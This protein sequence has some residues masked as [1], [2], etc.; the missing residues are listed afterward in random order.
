[1]YDLKQMTDRIKVLKMKHNLNS[2]ELAELAGVPIGTLNKVL[3]TETKDPQLSTVMKIAS[4][5][6]VDTD[7]L[8]YGRSSGRNSM[9]SEHEENVVIAYR[10]NIDMQ[11]AVDIILG[12]KAND[13]TQKAAPLAQTSTQLDQ[14]REQHKQYNV[15]M[16]GKAAGGSPIIA[17]EEYDTRYLTDV[18]CDAAVQISGDSMDPSYPDGCI[19]LVRTGAEVHSG[20]IVIALIKTTAED[21]D[22]TC[23][24]FFRDGDMIKLV[25]INP[26]YDEQLYHAMDVEIFGVVCGRIPPDGEIEKL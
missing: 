3:G 20:D 7:Y 5:L 11:P 24:R 26:A 12:V 19:A 13:G 22:V 4:A 16:F 25:S 14:V 17:L 10:D 8:I 6:N 21:T 1:M 15:R 23:K 2:E 9:F 18:H